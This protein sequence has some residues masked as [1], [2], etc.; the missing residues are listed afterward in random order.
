[1]KLENASGSVSWSSSDEDVAQVLNNGLVI[2]IAKG[3]AVITAINDGYK[4]N[5]SVKVLKP[6]LNKKKVTLIKGKTLNL[7][8]KGDTAVS[9]RSSDK[10]VAS[11]SK[12]GTVKAV[13][14][15]SAKIKV[16]GESGS[17]YTC[18][19][20]VCPP[21]ISVG[22]VIEMGKCEQDNNIFNGEELIEWEVLN[23]EDN[24]A[25]LVSK[26]V[27]FNKEYSATDETANWENSSLR[28]WLNLDFY[29]NCFSSAERKL[30]LESVV[31]A[32]ANP[33]ARQKINQGQATKDYIFCLSVEEVIDY[34]AYNSVGT[35]AS[36]TN[37]WMTRSIQGW[38]ATSTQIAYV[39]TNSW[40]ESMFSDDGIDYNRKCGVRPAMWIKV[41]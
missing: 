15:G 27:L 12:T 1:M 40:G 25:L 19:I 3:E 33:Y 28:T 37:T 23:V 29:D 6:S 41:D 7:K 26:Y 34:G 38:N 21:A 16:R 9:W 35:L 14:L 24:K 22:D 18:V 30:I 11:V 2:G 32:D 4:Y 31:T 8:L 39:F 13:G 20:T 5:C 10:Y 17:E 36:G